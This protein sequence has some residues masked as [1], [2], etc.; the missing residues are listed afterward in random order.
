V[1]EAVVAA[2]TCRGNEKIDHRASQSLDAVCRH[3][4]LTCDYAARARIEKSGDLRLR[5][6]GVACEGRID[7]GE[8]YLPATVDANATADRFF[9]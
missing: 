8:E 5:E 2:L 6:R 9:G 4:G 7:A 3:G 1:H